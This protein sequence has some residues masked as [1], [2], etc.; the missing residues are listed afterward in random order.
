MIL[1]GPLDA[2]RARDVCGKQSIHP[3]T[4]H[5]YVT[6]VSPHVCLRRLGRKVSVRDVIAKFDETLHPQPQGGSRMGAPGY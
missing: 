3:F 5:A 6:H 2:Q 4:E 1:P